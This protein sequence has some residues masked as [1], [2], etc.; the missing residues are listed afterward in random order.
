MDTN[1]PNA[2]CATTIGFGLR[3]RPIGTAFDLACAEEKRQTTGALQKLAHIPQHSC[4]SLGEVAAGSPLVLIRVHSWFCLNSR[5]DLL[6]LQRRSPRHVCP[7]RSSGSS[8][9]TQR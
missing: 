3:S 9:S 4:R 1:Q 5:T 6:K 8:T 7:K 2:T